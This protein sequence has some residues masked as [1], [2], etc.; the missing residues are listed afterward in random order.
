MPSTCSS[1]W[2]GS[3]PISGSNDPS[4]GTRRERDDGRLAGTAARWV[5]GH[6]RHA[7]HV[8]PDRREDA[9]RSRAGGE[10]LVA[11]R[12]LRVR[13]AGVVRSRS[14]DRTIPPAARDVSVTTDVWPALPLDGWRDTYATLHMWTQIVGKTR[15][16]LAP[17]ENH[18][19]HVAIYVFVALVWFVPDQRIE[20]SL[21]RHET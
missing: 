18:W 15:L 13:R 19:W 10:S 3:F 9:P 4:R 1:R 5:A 7:P 2:C 16:A 6:L 11:R 14:A 20:R 21:Q 8:D 12:H 17:A